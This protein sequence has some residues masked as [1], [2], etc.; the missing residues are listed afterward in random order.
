[1]REDGEQQGRGK[2]HVAEVKKRKHDEMYMN[3]KPPLISLPSAVR[4]S[5][6]EKTPVCLNFHCVL[7]VGA[8]V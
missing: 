8:V 7:K 4:N 5:L 2:R 1:M 6:Y 3:M